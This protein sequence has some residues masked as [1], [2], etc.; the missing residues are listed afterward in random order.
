MDDFESFFK[1]YGKGRLIFSCHS[2]ADIDSLASA[3]VLA[4]RFGNS[5]LLIPKGTNYATGKLIEE[6]GIKYETPETVL[7][8]DFD[9]IV[10]VDASNYGLYELDKSFPILAVFDHHQKSFNGFEGE[11]NFIDSNAKATAEIVFR[12]FEKTLDQE[13]AGLLGTALISDTSRFK[14]ATAETF[15]ILGKLIK[16]SGKTYEELL[17]LAY[18]PLP[19]DEKIAM[20]KAMQRVEF[21]EHQGFIIAI[22]QTGTKIAESSSL[23]AEGA[24]VVFVGRYDKFEQRSMVSARASATFPLPL[25]KIMEEVGKNFKSSGGGHPKASGAFAF[26]PLDEVLEY[27]VETVRKEIDRNNLNYE[28]IVPRK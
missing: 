9:G 24:D 18:P 19:N 17:N 13:D 26:A 25:N 8:A 11:F 21:F 12:I 20:L 22:S 1:K 3:Y 23:I 7:F 27:C 15:E 14:S 16:K 6:F 10:S 4:K 28:Q 2:R 5:I